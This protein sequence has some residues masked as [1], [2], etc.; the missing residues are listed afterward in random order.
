[1]SEP[2]DTTVKITAQQR[3]HPALRRLARACIALA[4]QLKTT[5]PPEEQ[6]RAAARKERTDA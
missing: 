4:R 1:M 2:S 6:R 3:V 5:P